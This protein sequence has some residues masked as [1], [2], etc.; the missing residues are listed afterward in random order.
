MA[1]TMARWPPAPQYLSR[2]WVT[3]HAH[4]R[5]SEVKSRFYMLH[6]AAGGA[7]QPGRVRAVAELLVRLWLVA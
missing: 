2:L 1:W 4:P 5:P 6:V 3:E 7:Q